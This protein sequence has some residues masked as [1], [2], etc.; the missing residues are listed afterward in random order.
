[1]DD[2]QSLQHTIQ[3]LRSEIV[4]LKS[5]EHRAAILSTDQRY[6]ESQVRFRTVFES[7]RLGNKIIAPDLKILEV[8]QAMVT[9]L[10]FETK[11][12]LIGAVILDFA[13]EECHSDWHFLQEKL[14][15][16]LSPSFSFETCL[17]KKDGSRVWCQITSILFPDNGQ[18]LGY[19]II[20]DITERYNLREQREEFISIASHELKTPI[21]SLQATIQIIHK[22]VT[23]GN[24]ITD[25]LKKFAGNAQ[26]Y[27]KKINH[28]V[29][30][31]LNMTKIEQGQ[32]DLN[33]NIFALSE[34]VDGCCD[35][36]NAGGRHGLSYTGDHSLKVTADQNKIEQVLVNFVN[37]AAKYAP[38]SYEIVIDVKR[39][40]NS[41]KVSVIDKGRGIPPGS[42]GKLFERYYRVDENN[43]QVAGLGLGLYVS[44]EIIKRHDGKIGVE[45]EPGIGSTF[46]FTL[47]DV[48]GLE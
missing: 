9:L 20:E 18:T 27:T 28:L 7:S 35:H 42:V 25:S 16:K 6:Q 48:E 21:T 8:N 4:N 45:S 37:N 44:S 23:E 33:K 13:P 29:E 24:I 22:M 2:I 30:D 43:E 41:T 39:K 46:W 38:E 12:D 26:R 3:Q 10:G 5:E 15:Q 36:I 31:L 34:L 40:G 47:P 17:Q 11:E 14:W 1:M 19:T 32:L